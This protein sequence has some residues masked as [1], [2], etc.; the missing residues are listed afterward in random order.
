MGFE[1]ILRRLIEYGLLAPS[2]YNSQPWKFLIEPKQGVIEI[3]ADEER[4]RPLEIDSRRRDL[5][6]ALGAYVEHMVL[7]APAL[8]YEIKEEL[9]PGESP[10]GWVARLALT[11]LPET[12]PETLFS[13]I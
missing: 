12:V 2:I 3:Y 9:F 8:G 5:Y 4:V 6:L 10:R 11:P 1:R 13:V 7:A